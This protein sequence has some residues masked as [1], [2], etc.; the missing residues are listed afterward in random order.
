MMTEN[1]FP[2]SILTVIKA[3]IIRTRKVSGF[4]V[5]FGPHILDPPMIFECNRACQCHR[6]SCNNRLVQHGITCR[7]VLFRIENKGWGVRASQPISKG[8]YVCE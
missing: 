7:L 1:W 8:S 3:M 5:T 2:N 4:N 6:T